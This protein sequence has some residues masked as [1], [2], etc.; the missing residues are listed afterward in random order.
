M[1][2]VPRGLRLH[3]GGPAVKAWAGVTSLR[4]V[5]HQGTPAG[6]MNTS[7]GLGGTVG[8]SYGSGP[9]GYCPEGQIQGGVWWPLSSQMTS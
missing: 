7:L 5:C 4:P 1:T 6:R 3:L 2:V 9:L 8:G